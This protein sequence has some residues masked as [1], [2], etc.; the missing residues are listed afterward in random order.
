[1]NYA[2][3]NPRYT[4]SL[5]SDGAFIIADRRALHG[6]IKR[7]Y[8]ANFVQGC[9]SYDERTARYPDYVHGKLWALHDSRSRAQIKKSQ[10][11]R[12]QRMAPLFDELR[13][14]NTTNVTEGLHVTLSGNSVRHDIALIEHVKI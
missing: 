2:P 14:L 3:K 13:K 10:A 11:A 4:V 9:M 8:P 1:M 12:V 5:A 7:F 6:N